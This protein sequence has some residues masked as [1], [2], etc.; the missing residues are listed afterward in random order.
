MPSAAGSPRQRLERSRGWSGSDRSWNQLGAAARVRRRGRC[1]STRCRPGSR[2]RPRSRVQDA[3]A[4]P[5]SA[6]RTRSARTGSRC[7]RDPP[8]PGCDRSR[9]PGPGARRGRRAGR[10]SRA[11]APARSPARRSR[12]V[13]CASIAGSGH[14]SIPQPC[15]DDGL[16]RHACLRAPRHRGAAAR[17]VGTGTSAQMLPAVRPNAPAPRALLGVTQ[18]E[19]ASVR[20]AA[21]MAAADGHLAAP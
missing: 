4:P 13:R 18:P 8:R 2:V 11:G 9:A 16:G 3:A 14:R 7:A 10:R 12:A 17:L 5:R 1:P 15:P 19:A 21:R 20:L 6:G